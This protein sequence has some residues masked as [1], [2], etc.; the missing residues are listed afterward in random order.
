MFVLCCLMNK[1]IKFYEKFCKLMHLRPMYSEDS[2]RVNFDVISYMK[3]D[4]VALIR[5]W[6]S[7]PKKEDYNLQKYYFIRNHK[8]D[9]SQDSSIKEEQ[10]KFLDLVLD[11]VI[12]EYNTDRAGSSIQ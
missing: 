10:M 11:S 1:E 9:F 8:Y 4:L 7:T 6:H 2:S 5:D 3:D 12:H